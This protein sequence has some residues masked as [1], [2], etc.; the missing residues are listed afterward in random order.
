MRQG[1]TD[2]TTS[3]PIGGISWLVYAYAPIIAGIVT[4][5]YGFVWVLALLAFALMIVGA[6][7]GLGMPQLTSI[8][9]PAGDRV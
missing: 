6:R 2:A 3:P 9:A 5:L 8:T 7:F 4:A 1:P